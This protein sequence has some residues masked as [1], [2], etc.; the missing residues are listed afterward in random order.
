[1]T[2]PVEPDVTERAW[3][4]LVAGCPHSVEGYPIVS[5]RA[6]VAALAP[7]AG[8]KREA[9]L[10]AA[11]RTARD[12]FAFY[13]VQHRAKQTPEANGK[14]LVNE[15]LR[16]DIDALLATKERTHDL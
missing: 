13:A 8:S 2:T 3:Q 4:K 16:D 11:L 9:E 12:Q 6:F 14:A 1:M 7:T 10:E 15:Q 5:H